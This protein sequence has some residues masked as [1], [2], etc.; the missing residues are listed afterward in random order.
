MTETAHFVVGAAI[1][2]RV[3]CKPLGLALAFAS[4][5]VLDAIPHFEHPRVLG[6]ASWTPVVLATWSATLAVG[7]MLWA[8]FRPGDTYHRWTRLYLIGGGLLG[9]LLD[10][11]KEWMGP[12]SLAWSANKVS[13]WWMPRFMALPSHAG[14]TIALAL[15]MTVVELAV[16]ALGLWFLFRARRRVPQPPEPSA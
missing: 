14:M 8:H 4:H 6:W 5:F 13:H 2:R 1:C 11:L 10:Q 16:I 3:R 12:H 9:G 15:V 7:I